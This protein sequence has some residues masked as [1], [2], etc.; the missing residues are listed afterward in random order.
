MLYPSMFFFS[1]GIS[2]IHTKHGVI[3]YMKR[4]KQ[5]KTK[6]NDETKT[7]TLETKTRK[8]TN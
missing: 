8:K 4:M 1:S 2:I 6:D 3:N 5:I 7:K